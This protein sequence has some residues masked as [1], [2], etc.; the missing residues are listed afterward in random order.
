MFQG[1]RPR[2]LVFRL[3]MKRTARPGL[4]AVLCWMNKQM[5]FSVAGV[6]P[7]AMQLTSDSAGN[8]STVSELCR[9]EE[10]VPC[11]QKWARRESHLRTSRTDFAAVLSVFISSQTG[12]ISCVNCT[13]VCRDRLRWSAAALAQQVGGIQ[14]RINLPA[15]CPAVVSCDRTSSDGS[16]LSH[17][18]PWLRRHCR[19]SANWV[20]WAEFTSVRV[21][22]QPSWKDFL[23]VYTL[24]DRGH[25]CDERVT[26]IRNHWTHL[27]GCSSDLKMI[28]VD[29]F[30][31]KMHK[32][33]QNQV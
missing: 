21:I 10:S 20:H 17:R 27:Q 32:I 26:P 2:N 4:T 1:M 13:R 9:D 18:L 33:Y 7:W 30:C 16:G 5:C 19:S 8:I 23:S 6:W 25:T 22:L 15:V 31:F 12:S 3:A 11:Q 28:R 14:S 29:L 24:L